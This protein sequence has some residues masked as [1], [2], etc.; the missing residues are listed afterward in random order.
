MSDK[1][2]PEDTGA[3]M[4]AELEQEL[5]ALL[6]REDAPAGLMA[7][8]LARA[9]AQRT[10]PRR[11]KP[12]A[13]RLRRHAPALS[14]G[15]VLIAAG[16]FVTA[17]LVHRRQVEARQAQEARACLLYALRMTTRELSWAE[18]K[19]NQDMAA[20]GGA[21]SRTAHRAKSAEEL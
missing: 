16:A 20:P 15:A 19:V 6:R 9:G 10:S 14:L 13:V 7:R 12:P 21:P 18:R 11:A 2:Q 1:P 17:G 3:A 8:V 4:D 5:R